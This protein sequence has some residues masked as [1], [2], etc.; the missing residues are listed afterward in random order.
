MEQSRLLP[1]RCRDPHLELERPVPAA[2]I[3]GFP[4]TSHALE[5]TR[6]TAGKTPRKAL[7]LVHARK[8]VTERSESSK[9]HAF[10]DA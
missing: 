9:S 2:L 1:R 10:A 6:T 3:A 4:G 5:W 7:N 8:M